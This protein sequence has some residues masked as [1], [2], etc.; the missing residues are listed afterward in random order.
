M[1]KLSQIL[2][3]EKGE[4]S[5]AQTKLTALYH[6]AQ[7]TVLWRGITRT[8]VPKDDEGDVLP[9]ESTPV[10]IEA[11]RHIDSIADG[12]T[13]LFD[14]VATKDNANT[15][16]AA[17]VVVDGTV[18]LSDVPVTTL[19][20]LEKQMTDLRTSI[21]AIPIHDTDAHWTRNEVTGIWETDPV[22]TTRSTKVP[23]NHVRAAATDKHPAQVDLWTEDVIVGYWTTR[24]LSGGLAGTQRTQLLTR[25][26]ALSNAVKFAREE[27]NTIDVTDIKIGKKIFDHLFA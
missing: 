11:G 22:T 18:V 15:H 8:Y 24:K 6:E 2:A 26:D 1:T 16:A 5:R 25:I 23:R 13:R 19:L 4:K 21:L 27:A 20:F 3:I 12:L 9:A 7:K 17:D 14:I 10:Q